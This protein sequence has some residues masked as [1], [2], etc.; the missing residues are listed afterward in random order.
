MKECYRDFPIKG[1]VFDQFETEY[2]LNK[3]GVLEELPAKR[4]CQA[5]IDSQVE[6]TLQKILDSMLNVEDVNLNPSASF[7]EERDNFASDLDIM[8]EA[9]R[10]VED[11]KFEHPDFK[12]TRNE[13]MN[14]IKKNVERSYAEYE[15]Q[16]KTSQ[17]SE[18]KELSPDGA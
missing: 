6:T 8:L 5:Y 2:I 17:E 13:I 9:D 3:D 16:I 11:Y 12:G 15:A 10:I 4:D 18:Q 14:E 1:T 7:I